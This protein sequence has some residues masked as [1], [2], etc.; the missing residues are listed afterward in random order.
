MLSVALSLSS[1]MNVNSRFFSTGCALAQV[2]AALVVAARLARGRRRRPPLVAPQGEPGGSV[3]VV[4]PARDEATRI[5]ACLRGL[6]EDP[7]VGEIVVVDDC[8]RDRTA[9]LAQA[10][11]A[12][13]V[14]GTEPPPGWVGKPW[15][16]EQGLRAARGDVV[17]SLDADTR[18]RP[19][20]VRAL[21]AALDGADLVAAGCRF[22]CETPGERWLHPAMLATLVY[23]F[24]PPD[25]ERAPRP[26]RVLANGQCTAVRRR[27]LLAAGGYAGAAGQL[28]DD[29][30]FARGLARAG[31][32]VEFRDGRALIDVDMHDS[33]AETWREWGRSLALPDVTSRAWRAADLAAVWL[34]LGLPPLRVAAGRARPLDWALLAVRC[35]VHGALAPVYARRGP[36]FWLAPL[37][38]PAVAVRLTW[39]SVRPARSWRGRTY[40]RRPRTAA[41]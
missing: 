26:A 12:R 22:V 7:D 25:A 38:D 17:V 33:A 6:R 15:A 37:A 41:R 32:R 28:T 18:P 1:A 4:I 27:A 29:A 20:L 9:E 23:R 5:G 40:A 13:V 24:G 3:S 14:T 8:S 10:Y 2:L 34:T 31:W 35:A 11:G 16:L 30:A 39:S 19:G 36:A 21:V